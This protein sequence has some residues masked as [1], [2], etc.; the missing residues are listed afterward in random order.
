M[1]LAARFGQ[2]GAGQTG[3]NPSVGCVI[4]REGRVVGFGWTGSGGAPHA[5]ALALARADRQ[6]ENADCF[7]TLEPCAHTGKTPPCVD[8]LIEAGIGRVF[9][10]CKDPDARVNGRGIA[11]LRAHGIAVETMSLPFGEEAASWVRFK[12]ENRPWVTL[13]WAQSLDGRI[14]LANRESRWITGESARRYAHGLRA[15][16]DAILTGIGTIKADDPELTCRLPG[17]ARQALRV[18]LDSQLRL[19]IDSKI[20]R[21]ARFFPLLVF[22]I[23]EA[24]AAKRKRL[25]QLGVAVESIAPN[26]EGRVSLASLCARLAARNVKTVLVEAGARLSAGFLSSCLVDRLCVFS[27]PSLIGGDGV[28]S[29]ASLQSS[30]LRSLPRWAHEASLQLG[31]DRLDIYLDARNE[32]R[33]HKNLLHKKRAQHETS[34]Y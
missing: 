15:R 5:E 27:A 23:P 13:K 22:A 19:P 6:A 20:V 8:L 28:A 32:K 16:H 30:D 17:I 2:R 12:T 21:S 24:P 3:E 7:V 25:E 1:E 11:R 10:G 34:L 33:L 18:V 14:G 4:A 9:I 29:C 26:A 31:E